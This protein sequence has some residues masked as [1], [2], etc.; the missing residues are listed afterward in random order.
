[1]QKEEAAS[2]RINQSCMTN[3]LRTEIYRLIRNGNGQTAGAIESL[4]ER[5]RVTVSRRLAELL[6]R[7]LIRH[8]DRAPSSGGRPSRIYRINPDWRNVIGIDVGERKS[9]VTLFD[10]ECRM[11]DERMLETDLTR[12]AD[13]TIA[14][15]VLACRALVESPLRT[16]PVV[17][18]GLALPA[19][20]DYGKGMVAS[21]SILFGWEKIAIRERLEKQ[22][23]LSVA[24]D[25]DVNLMCLA[26]HRL[27]WP[28]CQ[29]LIFVKVGTGIGCGMI[30]HGELLRGAVGISGDIGHIQHTPEPYQ[31]CRCGKTGCVEA[32]AAGWALARSLSADGHDCIDA[33]DVMALYRAGHPECRKLVNE[34]SRAL[35]TVCADLVAILN[36]AMLIIGGVLS[37]AGEAML[38]GIRERIYQRCL[39]LA[40][41]RLDI[42]SARGGDRLGVTGAAILAIGH[43]TLP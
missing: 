38:A 28:D 19:P 27:Y 21:P 16:G 2:H 25:N 37:E 7:D 26:E 20:I 6:E 39:P 5:S 40:T 18:V 24:L 36:P 3:T 35:G 42:K 12:P 30:M 17:S 34:S 22:L 15:L 9:R 23:G 1:M 31:L 43:I 29:D 14:Q 4:T 10:L 11:L 8:S 41:K 32:H 33:R 13:E